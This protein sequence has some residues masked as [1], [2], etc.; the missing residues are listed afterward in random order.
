MWKVCLS[1][2]FLNFSLS[3]QLN[4]SWGHH[5]G[6]MPVSI[7]QCCVEIGIFYTIFSRVSKSKSGILLYN[8]CTIAIYFVC[9]IALNVFICGDMELNPGPK[10]TK[11][12][13]KFS[14][15]HRNFNN[16]PTP[17]FSKPSLIEAYNTDH[18]FDIICLSETYLDLKDFTLIRAYNPHNGKW[19]G[20]SIFLKNTWLFSP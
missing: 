11:S 16:L 13:Y 18:N 14:F 5:L 12:S 20:V 2:L 10:N 17:D 15:C 1:I 6:A 4:R 19:D 8:Y 9:W 7:S 3:A